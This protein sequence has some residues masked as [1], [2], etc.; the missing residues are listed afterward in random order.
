[1]RAPQIIMIVFAAMNVG[2]GLAMHGRPKTGEHNFVVS[3][4][5]AVIENIQYFR[6]FPAYINDR[7]YSFLWHICSKNKFF[8]I[9]YKS[10]IFCYKG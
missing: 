7:I 2:M 3:L 10:T 9:L 5:G 6:I 4:L 8:S 1:M